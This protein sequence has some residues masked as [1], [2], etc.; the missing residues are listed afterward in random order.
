M[1]LIHSGIYV[2][3][4][5]YILLHHYSPR[6]YHTG[7]L[8]ILIKK[9]TSYIIM[10][11]WSK[12]GAVTSTVHARISLYVHVLCSGSPPW[13]WPFKNRGKYKE[14]FFYTK[15]IQE[16]R[17]ILNFLE[18]ELCLCLSGY[19]ILIWKPTWEHIGALCIL[20]ADQ[21]SSPLLEIVHMEYNY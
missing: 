9:V 4:S 15:T 14:Q 18:F 6:L 8:Y 2:A 21:L 12:H 16:S 7:Q 10:A 11:P 5:Y 1:H 3:P 13:K 20:L 19:I 17:E